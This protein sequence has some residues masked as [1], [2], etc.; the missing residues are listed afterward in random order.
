MA[1]VKGLWVPVE[2]LR[3]ER[4][5]LM[6][7]LILSDIIALDGEKGCFATNKNI[8]DFVGCTERQ[9]TRALTRLTELGLLTVESFDGRRRKCHVCIDILSGQHRHFVGADPTKCRGS[10]NNNKTAIN[11]VNNTAN[12]KN[13]RD[14]N[15]GASYSI[16][17]ALKKASEAPRVKKGNRHSGET[18]FRDLFE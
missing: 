18:T 10:I 13:I 16:E 8:A 3:D 14:P 17:K 15:E 5:S 9:V 4:L 11:T 6:E 7:K 1:D 12:N 2:V